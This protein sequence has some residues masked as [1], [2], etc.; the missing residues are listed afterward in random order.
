MAVAVAA[1][2]SAVA[3]AKMVGEGVA[4]TLAPTVFGND[5]GK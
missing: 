4:A 5:G 2:A 3:A 1:T